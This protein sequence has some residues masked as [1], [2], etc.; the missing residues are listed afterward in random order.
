MKAPF[1]MLVDDEVTL[2]KSM[3]RRLEKRGIKTISAYS[4]EECLEKLKEIKDLDVIVLDVK[5]PGMD[6][7]ETLREIKKFSPLIEVIMLTGNATIESGIKGMK[8]GAYDY[9]MKPCDI[10]ELFNKV[11]LA[12]Q[13]KQMHEEKIYDWGR[14]METST[15]QELMIPL[16]DYAT[17]SEDASILEAFNALEEAQRSFH[18]DRY[19]HMAILV[20]DKDQHVVG[21]LSQHDI[22]QALEPQYREIKDRQTTAS[23]HFGFSPAF[24]EEVALQ[25]T[26]WDRPL[27]NLYKKALEQKVRTFMYKPVDGDYIEVSATINETI[28]RLIVGKHQSLL[29]TDGPAGIVGIVRLTD[30][31]ELIHLRL[32]TLHLA[33]T[34][35]GSENRSTDGSA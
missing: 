4:G 7:I 24:V 15:L 17:V 30:V 33:A 13:K 25:F 31:F 23:D 19:R 2:V 21:K 28:H 34:I 9:L 18:P 3:A 1:I 32:K 20:L 16:D 8:S 35:A 11:M 27:Q 5:M 10:E 14:F 22:I 6:G 12:V 26:A 29:V